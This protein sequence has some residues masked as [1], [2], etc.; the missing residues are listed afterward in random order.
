M[1]PLT[2]ALRKNKYLTNVIALVPDVL[3]N[4]NNK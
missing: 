1:D 3:T 2:A 4:V